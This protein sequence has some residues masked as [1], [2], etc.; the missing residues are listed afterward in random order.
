MERSAKDLAFDKERT[1]YKKQIKELQLVIDVDLENIRMD[2]DEYK[3]KCEQLQ[4]WN[5]RLLDYLDLPEEEFKELV[6]QKKGLDDLENRMYSIFG[7]TKNI[8]KRMDVL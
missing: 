5:D 1:K 4:E 3:Q 2:L 6:Y 8:L 7:V